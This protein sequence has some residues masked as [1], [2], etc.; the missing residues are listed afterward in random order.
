MNIQPEFNIDNFIEN[1]ISSYETRI[2]KIQSAYQSSE[3]IQ[4]SY[5]NLF[6]HVHNSLNGLKKEREIL[7]SRI[8]E[9]LAKNGSLRKKDYNT[10]MS[11]I[12]SMLD[13]K[14]KEAE[15]QFA[16]FIEAQKEIAQSLRTSL[17]SIK[18]ISSE[19]AGATIT[20]VKE[21]LTQIAKFQEIRKEAVMRTF[22]NF[23]QIHNK[24]IQSLE[25]LLNKGDLIQVQD[26][27]NITK[28]IIRELN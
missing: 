17:L 16:V 26:I 10:M 5:H 6:D 15:C 1:I 21:H 13:Q 8:C 7:N 22:L 23:Q 14:E 27:K 24:M 2:Q 4:E 9:S 3:A 28:L 19:D 25:D 12:L 11:G 18:D 20:T